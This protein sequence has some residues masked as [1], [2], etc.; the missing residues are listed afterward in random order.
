MEEIRSHAIFAC[1]GRAAYEVGVWF[2][3]RSIGRG[4]KGL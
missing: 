2:I 4:E 1:K 3:Q